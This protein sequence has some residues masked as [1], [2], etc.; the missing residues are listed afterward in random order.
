MRRPRV[1]KRGAPSG[2]SK[3]LRP[4]GRASKRQQLHR[5]RTVRPSPP[6]SQSRGDRQPGPR[7]RRGTGAGRWPEPGGQGSVPARAHARAVAPSAVGAGGRRPVRD[8]LPSGMFRPALPVL[9]DIHRHAWS[10]GG[11]PWPAPRGPSAC[12]PPLLCPRGGR[13]ARRRPGLHP[14]RRR[15]PPG[16]SRAQRARPG[17]AAPLDKAPPTEPSARS[18][19]TQLQR[20]SSRASGSPSAER[21]E[22]PRPRAW[23]PAPRALATAPGTRQCPREPRQPSVRGGAGRSWGRWG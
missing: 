22:V 19:R 11:S 17:P 13:G 9:P 8:P 23:F 4:Q 3:P 21:Q 15:G 16:L 6:A 10:E 20:C 18:G 5:G 2:E 1:N 7:R 12:G 14:T